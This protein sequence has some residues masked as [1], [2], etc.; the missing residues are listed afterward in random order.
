[1][2]R[3]RLPESTCHGRKLSFLS[4]VLIII[5]A[6]FL[7][8]LSLV[9]FSSSDYCVTF[10]NT[11]ECEQNIQ[12]RVIDNGVYN[13]IVPPIISNNNGPLE[14]SV[15]LSYEA[16]EH[17]EVEDG[18]ATIFVSIT[19]KWK[20]ERL[21][22]TVD[23]YDTCSN[24]INVWTGHDI[25]TTSIWVPNFELLNRIEGVQEIEASKATVYS[26]GSV[27]WTMTGGLKT[28]CAFTGLANIPFDVRVML[29]YLYK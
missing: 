5:V 28:F 6:F 11:D 17:I 21:K 10:F 7:F 1:M 24:I 8:F 4:I 22:W 9:F 29:C 13:T 12:Q 15:F 3:R 18:T 23:D 20:D 27:V 2:R 26:D 14:V 19:L 16:L 25:E